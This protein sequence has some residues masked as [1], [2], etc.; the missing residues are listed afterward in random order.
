MFHFPAVGNLEKEVYTVIL[1]GKPKEKS[2]LG[3]LGVDVRIILRWNFNIW[4][5]DV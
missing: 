4:N 2:H 1:V 5:W 3:D